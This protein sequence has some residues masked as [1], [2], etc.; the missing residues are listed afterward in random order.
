M[1][2]GNYNQQPQPLPNSTA[3]LV[4]GICSIV[5][6]FCYG[7]IGLACG[8]IALAISQKS[9]ALYRSEPKAYSGWQNLNAGRICAIIGLSLSVIY[10]IMIVFI[11]TQ[12]PWEEMIRQ[13]QQN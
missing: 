8:I 9:V 12:M 6:C 10:I 11:G 2:T 13:S 3:T 1:E 7:I 5:G 4:L